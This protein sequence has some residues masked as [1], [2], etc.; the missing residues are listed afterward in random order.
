MSQ[1]TY[2]VTWIVEEK[3]GGLTTAC[4]QRASSFAEKYGRSNVVTFAYTQHLNSTVERLRGI[5]LLGQNVTVHN[6]YSDYASRTSHP[7][8]KAIKVVADNLPWSAEPVE[9]Q[10]NDAGIYKHVYTH[11]ENPDASRIV[12]SR[13]DG[14]KFMTDSKY[15][16]DGASKREIIL[17]NNKD[18]ALKRFTSA[19]ALYREWL[20]E[21]VGYEKSITVFDSSFV[22]SMMGAWRL[23]NATKMF[24]FHSSHVP[25]GQDPKKGK[26]VPKHQKIVDQ[27]SNW[28]VFVFLT[29]QQADD[30]NNRFGM[31]DK[32]VVIPNIIKSS[33]LKK[34]PRD[35]DPKKLISVGSLDGRKQVHHALH[36]VHELKTS[37]KE[38]S[39]TIVGKGAKQHE[40]QQLSEELGIS[41]RVSFVGHIDNVPQRLAKSGILLFTSKLEGQGLVLLEAQFHGCVPI[42]YDVRYGPASV[43]ESGVNGQLV[44]AH[45][46]HALATNVA[47]LIDDPKKYRSLSRGAHKSAKRYSRQ[48]MTKLWI[49]AS[50]ITAGLATAA[51]R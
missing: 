6:L 41:D 28:D 10:V 22:A 33:S 50:K 46:I 43:I 25:A 39:L 49:K 11:L 1:N 48:D 12:Y 9:S 7:P 21:I 47:S 31:S 19:S 29:Q 18:E 5:G 45:N 26:L 42:S 3:F 32:S 4:I 24:V 38:C 8:Q 16:I 51:G 14:S 27:A 44:E 37:G 23:P 20:S 30:F 17:F 35:N 36:A 2:M 34:F 13:A 40:L 15:V